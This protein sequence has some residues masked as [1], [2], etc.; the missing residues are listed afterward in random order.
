MICFR[1]KEKQILLQ[2]IILFNCKKKLIVT[3]YAMLQ[4]ALAKL[5]KF[6]L[7][8]SFEGHGITCKWSNVLANYFLAFYCIV[9][10]FVFVCLLVLCFYGYFCTWSFRKTLWRRLSLVMSFSYCL[11]PRNTLRVFCIERTRR[12]RENVVTTLFRCGIEVDCL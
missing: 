10:F 12:L 4:F 6:I 3:P 2:Y 7:G 8:G 1:C 5:A 9:L 11:S